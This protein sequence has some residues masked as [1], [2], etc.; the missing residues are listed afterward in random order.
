MAKERDSLYS[1]KH[2]KKTNQGASEQ[3]KWKKGEKSAYRGQG[4]RK[5]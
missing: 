2:K 4:G 5:R 3:S 1:G